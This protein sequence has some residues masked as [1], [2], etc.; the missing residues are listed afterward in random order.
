MTMFQQIYRDSKH[1]QHRDQRCQMLSLSSTDFW[2]NQLI[3]QLAADTTQRCQDLLLFTN[4]LTMNHTTAISTQ[5]DQHIHL[6]VC[7]PMDYRWRTGTCQCV[8]S[9]LT[10][11][12]CIVAEGEDSV[13]LQEAE[14]WWECV[15][16]SLVLSY[17]CSIK[18]SKAVV[19]QSSEQLNILSHSS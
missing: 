1:K 10:L 14:R 19:I 13:N 8:S 5:S 2:T 18:F 7:Y 4:S 9:V 11:C 17:R 16:E 15:P 6:L 12:H 3:N